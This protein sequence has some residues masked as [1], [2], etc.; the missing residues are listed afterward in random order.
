M[1]APGMFIRDLE[2]LT[3][4]AREHLDSRRIHPEAPVAQRQPRV[5]ITAE[6]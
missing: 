4:R 3:G 6:A 1:N 5:D 2:E